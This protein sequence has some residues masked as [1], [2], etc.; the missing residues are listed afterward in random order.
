M[1]TILLNLAEHIH[2]IREYVPMLPFLMTAQYQRR[3]NDNKIV[4]IKQLVGWALMIV[5][6]SI[7]TAAIVNRLALTR[8]EEHISGIE[9]IMALQITTIQRDIDKLE[10]DHEKMRDF[11]GMETQKHR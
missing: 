6:S 1:K 10:K 11:M 5:I 3:D 2:N 9:R 7:V 8:I 4:D